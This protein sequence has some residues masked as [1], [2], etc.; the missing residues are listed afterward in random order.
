MRETKFCS[1][2][3]VSFESENFYEDFTLMLNVQP[4]SALKSAFTMHV[5]PKLA[6]AP[7]RIPQGKCNIFD[8][9][10]FVAISSEA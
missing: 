2:A 10:C 7:L 5:N 1:S 6:R 8:A 3:Y 9:A 4:G